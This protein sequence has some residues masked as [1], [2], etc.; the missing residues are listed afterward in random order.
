MAYRCVAAGRECNGCGECREAETLDFSGEVEYYGET[1][2]LEVKDDEIEKLELVYETPTV[3]T[4]YVGLG[5]L[6]GSLDRSFFVELLEV[7]RGMK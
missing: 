1:F 3:E 2:Y 6:M 4:I 7:A 5:A